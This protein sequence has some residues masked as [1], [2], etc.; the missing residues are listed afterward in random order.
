[1]QTPFAKQI[2]PTVVPQPNS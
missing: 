2:L 1:M